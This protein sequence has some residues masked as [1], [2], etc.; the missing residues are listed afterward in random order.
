MTDRTKGSRRRCGGWVSALTTLFF[1]VFDGTFDVGLWYTL[2]STLQPS[3][4]SKFCRE[5]AQER[6]NNLQ[7]FVWASNCVLG[8]MRFVLRL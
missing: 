4:T 5:D 1:F 7:W 6:G 2:Q 3:I 8:G